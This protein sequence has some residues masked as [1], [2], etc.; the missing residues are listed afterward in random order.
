MKEELLDMISGGIALENFGKSLSITDF[1]MQP[2]RVSDYLNAP[3]SETLDFEERDLSPGG[4]MLDQIHKL[5]LEVDDVSMDLKGAKLHELADS[6]SR[7]RDQLVKGI[8]EK[9][10]NGIIYE[11]ETQIINEAKELTDNVILQIVRDEYKQGAISVNRLAQVLRRLIPDNDELQRMLPKLKEILLIEGMSLKDFLELTNELEKEITN[12]AVTG[13]LKKSAESIGVSGDDLL[14]EITSNP[15]EA[16][17]LIYLATEIRKG[18]G[19]KKALTDLLVEY[20]ERISG[21]IAFDSAVTQD[22]G[23]AHLKTVITRIEKDMLDRLKMKNM[24][25]GIMDAVVERLNSRIDNFIEKM[26]VNYSKR[27]SIYGT[28]DQET[29]SLIKMLEDNVGDAEQLKNILRKVKESVQDKETG[30][31]RA[32][33]L[34]FELDD[35]KNITEQVREASPGKLAALPKGVHNRKNILYFI[36]MEMLRSVRYHT[37]FTVVTFTMMKAIPQM[38][39][40]AGSISRDDITH[41]LLEE[42]LKISRETD[43]IGLLDPKK[44]IIMMPMT[45]EEDS[46]LAL[47]RL[48]KGIHTNLIKVNGISFELKMAGVAT[49]FD[50]RLTPSLKDFIGK[51]DHDIYDMVQRIKN[52]QSLY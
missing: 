32:D 49:P 20:I 23:D 37:S 9:K 11:N 6:V 33:A 21:G 26:E 29:T 18:S 50:V 31:F 15:V 43:F 45:G 14:R 17:E 7:M 44:I 12:K 19:D 3:D 34:K 40:A 4:I 2:E 41:A 51:I 48:T 36:E 39:F 52:L 47:R 30:E 5:R 1:L 22:M 46:K 8:L 42:F 27:S 10:K 16:A 38:K 24:D 25:S 28:W 35:T 13:A